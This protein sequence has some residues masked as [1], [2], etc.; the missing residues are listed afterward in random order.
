[1][2]MIIIHIIVVSTII[3]IIIIMI[4]IM[5]IIIMIVCSIL[6]TRGHWTVA[7]RAAPGSGARRAF[8]GRLHT[9]IS[10]FEWFNTN[11]M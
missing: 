7:W 4:M 3:V 11:I 9:C 8:R 5:V 1:M 6:R 2:I 10:G